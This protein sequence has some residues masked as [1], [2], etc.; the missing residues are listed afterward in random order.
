MMDMFNNFIGDHCLR[1]V[2][3][4][5]PRYTWTNKQDDPI[6]VNLDRFLVAWNGSLGS[7]FARLGA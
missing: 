6:M 7:L 4:A 2:I 1:E 3:R 5:G